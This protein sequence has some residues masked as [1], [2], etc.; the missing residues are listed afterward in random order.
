VIIGHERARDALAASSGTV[1]LLGP[2]SVGKATIARD[3]VRSRG[4]Q[5]IQ[6]PVP[7]TADGARRACRYASVAP[8]A[9]TKFLITDL[10]GASTQALNILLKVLEEPPSAARF[11]LIAST[12]TLDTIMSR[13]TV[14]RFGLLSADQ[15]RDIL[16]GSGLDPAEASRQ[17]ALGGG[18]VR[19]SLKADPGGARGKAGRV[20]RVLAAREPAH[21]GAALRDWDAAAHEQ[22]GIWAYEAASGRWQQFGPD[23][24]PGLTKETARRLLVALSSCPAARPRLAAHAALAPLCAR[25]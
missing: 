11:L 10:D 23:F 7:L 18:R 24:A 1:L 6:T 25:R 13:C 5:F 2:E 4:G 16:I 15:V 20:L 17:A 21:L 8:F 3:Y 9:G 14:L 19:P 22:L 12:P